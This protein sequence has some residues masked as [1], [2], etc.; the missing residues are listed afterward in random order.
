MLIATNVSLFASMQFQN[1]KTGK[2]SDSAGSFIFRF[3]EWPTD[4][5]IISYVGY[6]DFKLPF[7]SFLLSRAKNNVLDI[8]ILMERG[9]FAA[10]IV[11]KKVDR[12]LLMWKLTHCKTQASER[13]LPLP[14]LSLRTVQQT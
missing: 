12:G 8:S 13:P 5:L 7:D 4:T 10:V 11:K 2:L 1:Q 3:N 9:N 6:Q 14:Q